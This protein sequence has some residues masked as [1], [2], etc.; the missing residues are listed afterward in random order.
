M[1]VEDMQTGIELINALT[2]IREANKIFIEQYTLISKGDNAVDM[3]KVF[4]KFYDSCS[5]C[6]EQIRLLL[7]QDVEEKVYQAVGF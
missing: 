3:L 1:K 2:K 6:E 7:L 5:V 4:N